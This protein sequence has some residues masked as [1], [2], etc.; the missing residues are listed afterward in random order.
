[1]K[2]LKQIRE[3]F[4]TEAKVSMAKLKAGDKVQIL[5][6]GAGARSNGLKT[7]ENPYGEGNTVQILGFGVVPFKKKSNKRDVIARSIDDFKK[8]YKQE[9][10]DLK[11][12]DKY[13]RDLSMRGNSRIKL[14]ILANDIVKNSGFVGFIYQSSKGPGLLYISRS[15]SDDKWAVNFGDDM[16]FDLVT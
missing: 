2:T 15:L 11:S 1:M 8:K 10:K 6:K 12:D 13:D 16:E 4:L 3:E 14:S 5:A 9:I 7:G